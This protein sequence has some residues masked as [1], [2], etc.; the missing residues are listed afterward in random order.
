MSE[1]RLRIDGCLMV[2]QIPH[3]YGHAIALVMKKQ[4][5]YVT[6]TKNFVLAV[7]IEKRTIEEMANMN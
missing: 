1:A 2:V 5:L 3:K 6:T 7:N 4:T